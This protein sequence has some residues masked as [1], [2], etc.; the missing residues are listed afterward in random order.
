M[1]SLGQDRPEK[2]SQLLAEAQQAI[3]RARRLRATI[4]STLDYSEFLLNV[5]REQQPQLF[6]E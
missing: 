5:L 6:C 2:L 3:E 4:D 1:S